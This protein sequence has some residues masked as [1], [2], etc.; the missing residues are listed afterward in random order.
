MSNDL[1]WLTADTPGKLLPDLIWYPAVAHCLTCE[2]LAH[3]R[4]D[5]FGRCV[6]ACIVANDPMSWDDLLRAAPG[7]FKSTRDPSDP[8]DPKLWWLFKHA[9]YG[10]WNEA[11]TSSNKSLQ[12]DISE[13]VP[14]ASEKFRAPHNNSDWGWLLRCE[15]SLLPTSV[16]ACPDIW[17]RSTG[18]PWRS[19]R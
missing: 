5:M 11:A 4:P 2:K 3:M 10:L 14:D 17:L 1:S 12:Q 15:W 8:E 16:P 19:I 6:R 13:A 18:V 7:I 9:D